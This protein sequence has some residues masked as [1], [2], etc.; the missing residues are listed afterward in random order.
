MS[1]PVQLSEAIA[2]VGGQWEQAV[3]A[4]A[5][6]EQ[7]AEKFAGLLGRF[8]HFASAHG[9]SELGDVDASLTEA[10]IL[11]RGRS[12]RGEVAESAVATRRLR[13]SVL[14]CFFRTARHLLLT[15]DDP[16]QDI[17]LP[18]RPGRQTR[19]LDADEASLVRH[20]AQLTEAATRHAATVALALAGVHS[21]EIGYILPTDVD[22]DDGW[23]QAP[24]STRI[25]SR[26]CP[27]D[28]W[29]SRAIDRRISQLPD[30]SMP[31]VG[32]AT[33]TPAQRQARVGVTLRDVLVRAGLG[34]DPALRPASL[35]AHSALM[36]FENTGRI[37]DAARLLGMA[38][39]DRAADLV[40]Y[41]WQTSATA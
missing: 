2:L 16:A 1:E 5:M 41:Q 19:P 34:D 4:G 26:R 13:R 18:E 40:G 9:V 29:A 24:G 10:F 15:A 39:L 23:V 12:R 37:E 22:C 17:V 31:V 28:E 33:G 7:T 32:S 3:G 14:R 25:I 11:A 35:T 21:A 36:T 30:S 27:L 6:S 38:S 8:G 20:F